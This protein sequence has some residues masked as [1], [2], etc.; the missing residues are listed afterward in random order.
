MWRLATAWFWLVFLISFPI[1]WVLGLSIV[2]FTRRTDPQLRAL[3]RFSC[4]WCHHYVRLWPGWKVRFIDLQHL[5]AGPCVL[6]ANHQSMADIPALM[7]LPRLFKFVAKAELFQLPLLGFMLRQLQHVPIQ[8]GRLAS[9]GQMLAACEA[10]LDAG[11]AVLIFPEGTYATRPKRLPF[12]R[13]AFALARR[14]QVPLVPVLVEGTKELVFEDGPRFAT[15]SDVRITVKAPLTPPPLEADEAAWAE[16]VERAYRGWLSVP[17]AGTRDS[18]TRD[19]VPPPDTVPS[20][21]VTGV[22]RPTP[23]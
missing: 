12:R 13:G 18:E 6:I 20:D 16:Q 21:T 7:G 17:E 15:E 5:P 3:H 8:R 22:P 2:I 10:L 1:G 23:R 9:T 19:S 4:W 14:K 11:H